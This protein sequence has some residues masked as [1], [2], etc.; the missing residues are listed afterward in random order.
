M[1][2]ALDTRLERLQGVVNSDERKPLDE[3]ITELTKALEEKKKTFN[4]L[5]NTLKESEVILKLVNSQF[6]RMNQ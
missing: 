2:M 1:I 6:F 5:T 3:K 4:M